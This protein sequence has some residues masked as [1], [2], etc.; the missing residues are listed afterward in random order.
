MITLFTGYDE[1]DKKK[2]QE[3]RAADEAAERAKESGVSD[4]SSSPTG[5]G[6][7]SRM[8]EAVTRTRDNFSVTR[9]AVGL[10]RAPHPAS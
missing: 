1:E 8:R 3:S 2:A 5:R 9:F 6:F 10:W 7:F 4:D